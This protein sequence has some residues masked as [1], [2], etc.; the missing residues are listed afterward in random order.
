MLYV[1]QSFAWFFPIVEQ[2]ATQ[3][4]GKNDTWVSSCLACFGFA[5]ETSA[6]NTM[7][8]MGENGPFLSLYLLLLPIRG[9]HVTSR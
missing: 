5:Y 6:I 8:K 9:N 2:V 3:K 7:K 1:D 4:V